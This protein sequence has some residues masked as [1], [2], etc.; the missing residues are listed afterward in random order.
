M[1]EFEKYIVNE[2][3]T[4]T[5]PIILITGYKLT[6]R[7]QTRAERWLVDEGFNAS[8]LTL[9]D[10]EIPTPHGITNEVNE[11]GPDVILSFDRAI[12]TDTE[13]NHLNAPVIALTKDANQQEQI[14]YL[15]SGA[16]DIHDVSGDLLNINLLKA[17]LRAQ[18]RERNKSANQILIQ[19]DIV[20]S[21]L[22][23]PDEANC[24]E[25]ILILNNGLRIDLDNQIATFNGKFLK[26]AVPE[27]KALMF[28]AKYKNESVTYDE[29]KLYIFG[30]GYTNSN[31]RELISRLKLKLQSASNVI[32]NIRGQGYTLLI[33]QELS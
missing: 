23:N 21:T 10:S 22:K 26:L 5:K 8:I 18:L 17:K 30:E 13:V 32:H 16:I 3:E 24:D 19:Q 33:D 7:M 20:K 27:R 11:M 6:E 25:P 14:D 4:T 1:R 2:T 9:H 31:V 15:E 12:F 28:L 29:L